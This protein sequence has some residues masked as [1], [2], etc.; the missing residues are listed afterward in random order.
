[1]ITTFFLL[2]VLTAFF[3]LVG[4]VIGGKKGMIIAFALACVINFSAYWFSDS[5]ILAA[6]QARP[7]PAGHRL[8]RI[9]HELSRRAGMPAPAV[10]V[11]SNNSPNAFATGRSP[12][13]AAV[14]ATQGLL[15]MMSDREIAA[16]MSHELG[17]IKNRD[18]L[19]ATMAASISGGIL[20]LS[21]MSLFFGGGGSSGWGKRLAVS[22]LAPVAATLVT[23]ALSREREYEADAFS[24]RLTGRP[25]DLADALLGLERAVKRA[26]MPEH[27][28][29]TA[30]LFIVHPFSGNGIGELFSTHPPMHKRVER[31]AAMKNAL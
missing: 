27:S 21:R 2:F 31:L 25:M 16:V 24:A 12:E 5:M 11:I 29:E 20:I 18:T 23:L 14:A 9:T 4:R 17:H 1:M 30:H 7:V 3:L 8:E 15:D 26:P 19:V 13:H 6:Y 28:P 22:I 10:H